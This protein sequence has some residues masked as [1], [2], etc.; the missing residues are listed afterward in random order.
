MAQNLPH[1][2]QGFGTMKARERSPV[3]R[4][5]SNDDYYRKQD[6][7]K[8]QNQ[9]YYNR[10][11]EQK[12]LN[13]EYEKEQD[14]QRKMDEEY[15]SRQKKFNDE[16]Y[17]SLQGKPKAHSEGTSEESV[18]TERIRVME[19]VYWKYDNTLSP[20][21]RL[22]N[23]F[24]HWLEFHRD[25]TFQETVWV[26]WAPTGNAFGGGTSRGRKVH[27]HSTGKYRIIEGTPEFLGE[28][29]YDDDPAMPVRLFLPGRL[30]RFWPPEGFNLSV[31]PQLENAKETNWKRTRGVGVRPPQWEKF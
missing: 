12:R 21:G 19:A 15:T 10:Q 6:E 8:R 13:N 11:D 25:G 16:R 5:G 3:L 14:R 27:R 30:A 22:F 31:D 29:I 18:V 28:L 4:A 7:Q 26:K 2:G 24:D 1:N 17:K 23:E 9:D 20:D